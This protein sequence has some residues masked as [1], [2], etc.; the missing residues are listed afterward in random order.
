MRVDL[1]VHTRHSVLDTL[2]ALGARDCYSEPREVYRRARAR[3]MDLVTFTDHDTI[4]GCLEL[5]SD[6]GA[7]ADFF[8]SEEV[9]TRDPHSGCRFHIGV[10]GIDEA[11]HQEIQYL[12]E[13]VRELLEYLS[14]KGVPVSL[15][16]L[17]SS[18]VGGRTDLAA[19]VDLLSSF[20][21]LETLNGAQR[22]SSNGLADRL[23]EH[24]KGRGCH[25]GKTGGS[26]AHTPHRVGWAWTEAEAQDRESFLEALRSRQ[27]TPGGASSPLGSLIRDVYE[28]V[29]NYYRDVAGNRNGHFTSASR[30]KAAVCALG[31]LPLHLVAL[32]ATGTL[33][34]YLQVGGTVR[35]VTRELALEESRSGL[36]WAARPESEEA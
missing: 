31:S 11:G 17:G 21:L 27:T 15:N 6:L 9:S 20:P 10:Y 34:R 4:G 23:A 36:W 7:L 19:L 22:A 5:L 28:I 33:L 3:G 8:I 14:E 32:P 2:P 25:V 13:D 30:K 12:R 35:Q 26:D 1:H 24:V 18:L 16:H 29:L